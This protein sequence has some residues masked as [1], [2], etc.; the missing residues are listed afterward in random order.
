MVK[1][2]VSLTAAGQAMFPGVVDY[3]E[4]GVAS[5]I[6]GEAYLGFEFSFFDNVGFALDAGYQYL[7][8]GMINVTQG[9]VT[10]TGTETAGS[11]MINTNGTN[12]AFDMSNYF[13]GGSFRIYFN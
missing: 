6:M 9:T 12:R 13:A 5:T 8:V 7:P 1:N 2:T 10:L 3:T 11:K 4:L